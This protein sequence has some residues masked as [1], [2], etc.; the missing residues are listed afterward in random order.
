ML[1]I[2]T[3]QELHERRFYKGRETFESL[4]TNLSPPFGALPPGEDNGRKLSCS[5]SKVIHPEILSQKIQ[6]KHSV[7]LVDDFWQRC[8]SCQMNGSNPCGFDTV[9][10]G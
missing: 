8:T 10:W 7:I 2:I 6:K 1:M 9:S 4:A 3:M 5:Q